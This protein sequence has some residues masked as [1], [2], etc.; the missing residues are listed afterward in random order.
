MEQDGASP[1]EIEKVK[2]FG[3]PYGTKG[4]VR[5][6]A[7][8]RTSEKAVCFYDI[9]TGDAELTPARIAEIFKNVRSIYRDATT[10][11]I[12]QVRPKAPY[13]FSPK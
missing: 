3:F 7:L 6:D 8:E 10:I 5:V 9:K 1:E 13:R 11:V 4:S 12:T 2:K